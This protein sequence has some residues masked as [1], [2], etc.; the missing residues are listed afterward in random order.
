MAVGVSTALTLTP[1]LATVARAY[2]PE[3]VPDR[4]AYL[5]STVGVREGETGQQPIRRVERAIGRT[6]AI[7]HRYYRWDQPLPTDYERATYR[8]GRLPFLNWKAMR[9]DGSV[10]PWR[11]IA[12]GIHDEWI[13][14]QA[15]RFKSF[16]APMYLTFHH[17][18]ED[19]EA[20][21]TPSEFASAF[22][23]VVRIFREHGV[24]NVAFVWTMMAWSFDPGSGR[25]PMSWYPGTDFVDFI[26]LDGYNWYPLREGSTWRSFHEIMSPAMASV[27]AVGKPVFVVEFGVMEDPNDPDRKADWFR[28][29]AKTVR[30]WPRIKGLIYY[31]VIKDGW[32][33]NTDS[34]S[35]ALRGYADMAHSRWLSTRPNVT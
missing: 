17:E 15:A 20:F 3:L 21:G 28:E 4:G 14:E 2:P 25:D 22:R 33:W 19:D 24:R 35:R 30:D 7:D 16:G 1:F 23:H 5:G 29:V 27:K 12:G 13:A 10:V 6:L 9:S 32:P 31:D 34:S 26:G 18:P 11:D 8:A